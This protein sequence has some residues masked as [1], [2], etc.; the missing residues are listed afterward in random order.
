MLVLLDMAQKVKVCAPIVSS[1]A[2]RCNSGVFQDLFQVP[3]L[4]TCLIL[5]T[6]FGLLLIES[7]LTQ[8]ST[9]QTMM[10]QFGVNAN[11]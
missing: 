7:V 6:E 8:R 10:Y 11:I 2:S 4:V 9:E 5:I 1:S 3:C